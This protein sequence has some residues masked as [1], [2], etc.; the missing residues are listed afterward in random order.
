MRANLF[1]LGAD[2]G[3]GPADHVCFQYDQHT[4]DA[5]RAKHVILESHPERFQMAS[6]HDRQLATVLKWMRLRVVADWGSAELCALSATL[7]VEPRA[8][9]SG[10]GE[11]E[12]RSDSDGDAGGDASL[13]CGFDAV[14]RQVA[15]DFVVMTRNGERESVSLVHVCF[16][17]GWRPE[18]LLGR[19]FD[20][21]HS[22][23]P[24]FERIATKSNSLIQAMFERGPYVR[25]VWTLSPGP[26]LD[27][28]PEAD[29][30]SWE[31]QARGYLRVERQITVPF[32]SVGACLFLIRV[33]LY[34][35]TSL[36][37]EQRLRLGDVLRQSSDA[38]LA[39]KGL[40]DHRAAILE[41]L[42]REGGG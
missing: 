33:H 13:R 37:A 7:G 3:N 14:A 21:I 15:E 20:E 17:S 35:L 34:P 40:L 27:R 41:R 12:L 39:Y 2:F 32:S 10:E 31:N 26:E 30:T 8:R 9:V 18:R 38:V 25:F 28:H 4:T 6:G 23:I 5:R 11:R 16:P 19:S 22:P 29:L 36:T 42:R 1:R 24:K